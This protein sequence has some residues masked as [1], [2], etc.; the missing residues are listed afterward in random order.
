[1]KITQALKKALMEELMNELKSKSQEK[2]VIVESID[3]KEDAKTYWLQPE[4]KVRKGNKWVMIGGW[5]IIQEGIKKELPTSKG[6]RV[7]EG[8]ELV[9]NGVKK[10]VVYTHGNSCLTTAWA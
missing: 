6:N 9:K 7:F 5:K 2:K 8:I 3:K 10:Q 4:K 1:M